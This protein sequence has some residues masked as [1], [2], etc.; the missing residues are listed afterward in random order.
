[1]N[2]VLTG[3]TGYI[4]Q[5]LLPV[6]VNRGHRV[7]CAVRDAG[8]FNPPGSIAERVETAECDF[9]DAESLHQLPADVDTA[10]YLIHSMAGGGDYRSAEQRSAE[11]FADWCSRAGVRQVIYLGGIYNQEDLSEHLSS[12]KNVEDILSRGSYEF[13][14]LRAGIII[15]SGSASYEIIRDLVEKLPVMVTPRW[16]NTRSQPIAVRDVIA[17]LATAVMEPRYFG[18]RL[19]IGGPDILTYR[20]MLLGYAEVRGLKR[21]IFTVPVM[22]PK[23]SSYWLYFVTA[24]SFRLASALVDSMKVEVVCRPEAMPEED[25]IRPLD[26]RSAI[27]RSLEAVETDHVISSWKDSFSSGLISRRLSDF[28]RVPSHGCRKDIRRMKVRDRQDTIDRLWRIGGQTGW[29]FADFLW[30]LRGLMDKMIGG[31]GLRRGR[32]HDRLLQAGDA[33]D[34]WRVLYADRHEGRLLLLA[35]MKLPGEAWLEWRFEGDILVQTASFRPRGLWGRA[36]WY[37]VVPLHAVVFRGMLRA[38]CR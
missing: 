34:F 28:I 26:Y 10:F 19:D 25:A 23:L 36:Y 27:E 15:G 31:V 29:Y 8:R 4:G 9:M 24:T 37:S 7:T 18:K 21:R 33:L 6:L 22:T 12:R 2:I 35:E 30:S 17:Y 13:T 3:A 11:H 14:A 16:L 20:E 32:T 1:M 38:L 5:R